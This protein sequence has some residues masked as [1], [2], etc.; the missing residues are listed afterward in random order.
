MELR[1][2][3]YSEDNQCLLH[4][5]MHYL[6]IDMLIAAEI[7]Y[8]T[9]DDMKHHP[10]NTLLDG[11]TP[12]LIIKSGGPDSLRPK[13]LILDIFVGKS[14]NAIIEKK[15]KYSTMK[16][17]FDFTLLTLANYN[18]ELLKLF[19]QSDVAYFHHQFVLLQAEYSYWH[20]CLKF[21]KI[22]FNFNDI[23]N[24]TIRSL[25]EATGEFSVAMAEFKS[26]LMI[27]AEHIMNRD[28]L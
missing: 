14:Q 12:D 15:A 21:K 11:M 23:E 25:P 4:D 24:S 26:C 22:L 9:E 2:L 6:I 19:S 27:K 20:A 10:L 3:G 1:N 18:T 8:L 7:P 13:T 17:F 28:G 16:M 5:Y